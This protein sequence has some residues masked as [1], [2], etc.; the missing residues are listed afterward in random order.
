MAN[1]QGAPTSG[2]QEEQ[3]TALERQGEDLLQEGELLGQEGSQLEQQAT[4]LQQQAGQLQQ[5][6]DGLKQQGAQQLA[7]LSGRHGV[8]IMRVASGIRVRS[9]SRKVTP[10]IPGMRWSDGEPATADDV[11]YTFQLILDAVDTAG[12]FMGSAGLAF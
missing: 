7:Q 8:A 9:A 1:M 2:Q 10:S 5:E 12:W 11:A 3:K 6:G 4:G